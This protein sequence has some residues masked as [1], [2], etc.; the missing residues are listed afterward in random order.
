[1]R[2]VALLLSLAA[3]GAAG[4]SDRG[5]RAPFDAGV[6]YHV[7]AAEEGQ[8]ATADVRFNVVARDQPQIEFCAARLEELRL[9]FLRMGGSNR[10]ITGSYQGQFIFIDRAGVSFGKTLTGARFVALARTGDGRLAMPGAI[11]RD[12][13]G[14][15]D[16]VAAPVPGVSAPPA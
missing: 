16:G 5:P 3:V 2:N 8:D 4:C 13:D 6:C 14:V 15:A 9:R 12:I 1:M 7:A 10:E 11:Q